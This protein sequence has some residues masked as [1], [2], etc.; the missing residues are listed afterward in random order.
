MATKTKALW[1]TASSMRTG[2]LSRPLA[3]TAA[4]LQADLATG[5]PR[6]SDHQDRGVC[7]L[8]FR[9]RHLRREIFHSTD[10]LYGM[11]TARTAGLAACGS[12]Q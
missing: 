6:P 3:S 10:L 7:P 11:A 4:A 1:N 12:S 5:D 2:L 8:A 9:T